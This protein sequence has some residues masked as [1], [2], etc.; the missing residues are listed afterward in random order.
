MEE[1][2]QIAPEPED[3][4]ISWKTASS[5]LLSVLA[6]AY[7]GFT[8]DPRYFG[9]LLFFPIRQTIRGFLDNSPSDVICGAGVL[10]SYPVLC[11]SVPLI[12]NRI[13][14][15]SFLPKGTEQAQLVTTWVSFTFLLILAKILFSFLSKLIPRFKFP[16]LLH[17]S[18][19]I[20]LFS[21]TLIVALAGLYIGL[22]YCNGRFLAIPGKVSSA[23]PW[24]LIIIGAG[25]VFQMI[26]L[27]FQATKQEEKVAEDKTR[28]GNKPDI[29]L[30]DV[31]GME[32]VKEQIRLR[33]IEPV[34]HPG[35]A[36]KYGLKA[37][38]G[39]LLYGPPGTGKT[40][41]ARAIAGELDLPFYMITS[42]DIFGKYV[43]ESE[44][45]LTELFRN[46][47]KNPLSV[48]FID[49]L[50]NIFTKRTD[51]IHETTRKVISLILQ[52]LDGVDQKRN[53]ILLLGATNAP[54][55]IDE[56]FLRP[57]R[58]DIL[59]FVGLPDI[60]ARKQ[61]LNAAFKK[62]TL[63]KEPGLIEYLADN[64]PEFSGADLNGV[65][66]MI[67]QTAYRNG[68]KYFSI[69]ESA[70]TLRKCAPASNRELLLRIRQWE[71]TR[72]R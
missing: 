29:G 28:L 23:L 70:K 9:L 48:V 64:T 13:L 69:A 3:P 31:A 21:A 14:A 45:N 27:V 43:G 49:E 32:E 30:D 54:W 10:L 50:E 33:L 57:G 5:L 39:V 36:Q 60:Q 72:R 53:P 26:R 4:L 41:L 61:I 25:A 34:R 40:F 58:F 6:A 15:L 19:I 71:S 37:G 66:S 35:Q 18:L 11:E 47:R 20:S 12:S 1:N 42:S 22:D 52:E 56:A 8:K 59:S 16:R 7:L 68:A 62:S 55:Q 44:K 17:I 67:Q 63:P 2:V 46:I 65:V 38:G 24:A 51:Q